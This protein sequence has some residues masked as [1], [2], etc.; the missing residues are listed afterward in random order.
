MR[1]VRIWTRKSETDD[2]KETTMTMALAGPAS[3]VELSPG[4]R[5]RLERAIALLK[6]DQDHPVIGGLLGRLQGAQNAGQ[7]QGY[8]DG[9]LLKPNVK[10]GVVPA[11]QSDDADEFSKAM[12]DFAVTRAAL[13]K[14]EAPSRD[15]LLERLSKAEEDLQTG[16]LERHSASPAASHAS[17]A[18]VR[19]AETS[20]L[21][22]R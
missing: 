21:A 9:P 6:Q 19:K 10:A 7:G 5:D 4:Q 3:E 18:A 13:A 16:Y 1:E 14:S 11:G 12:E 22:V 20:G 8:A 2:E 17:R 15:G